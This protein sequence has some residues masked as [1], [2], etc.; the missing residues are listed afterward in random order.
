MTKRTRPTFSPAKLT[1]TPTLSSSDFQ[2][3]LN[4]THTLR[5]NQFKDPDAIDIGR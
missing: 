3:Y 5:S 2:V 4:G 1:R